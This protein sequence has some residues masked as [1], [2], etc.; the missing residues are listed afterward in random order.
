MANH[1]NSEA[2]NNALVS[3][4][5]ENDLFLV[6]ELLQSGANPEATNCHKNYGSTALHL[7]AG[8]GN[9][10][11]CKILLDYGT[12][13]DAR[14]FYGATPL[15]WAAKNNHTDV[16][17]LLLKHGAFVDA[18]PITGSQATPYKQPYQ[19]PLQILHAWRLALPKLRYENQYNHHI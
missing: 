9:V 14:N 7:A 2:L 5:Q 19:A 3:A 1:T 8:L 11:I 18:T 4:I 17:D 13:V 6:K 16:C 10:E 12:Q 15:V